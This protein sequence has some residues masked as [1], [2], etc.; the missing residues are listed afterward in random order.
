MKETLTYIAQQIL[1]HPND[2]SVDE[3][4]DEAGNVQLTLITHP[5]DTA[6]AIGKQ[7]RTVKALRELIK[8]KAIQNNVRI[9]LDV[10]SRDEV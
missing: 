8:I 6:L 1:P 7:G 2:F 10:R 5:E 3:Q 9:S 4:V